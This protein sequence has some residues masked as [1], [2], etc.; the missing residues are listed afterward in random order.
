MHI[1][2]MVNTK[3]PIA[4]I[5]VESGSQGASLGKKYLH[6]DI[7]CEKVSV[8]PLPNKQGLS[9]WTGYTAKA[10]EHWLVRWASCQ[11]LEMQ[12]GRVGSLHW[13]PLSDLG[14]PFH[15]AS[16]VATLERLGRIYLKG[17]Q[18]AQEAFFRHM[19]PTVFYSQIINAHWKLGRPYQV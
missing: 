2:F 15:L 10:V 18:M 6:A 1:L 8:S 16:E 13:T 12:Q 4:L 19:C 17:S 11:Q 5:G 7:H 3:V 14:L 9:I